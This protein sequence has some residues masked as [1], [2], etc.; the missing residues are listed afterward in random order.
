MNL[1]YGSSSSSYVD[2]Q[3]FF[4]VEFFQFY[5]SGVRFRPVLLHRRLR[6]WTHPLWKLHLRF[7]HLQ[8]EY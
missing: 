7:N 4:G 3:V 8:D 5:Q 6:H 2:C 1:V